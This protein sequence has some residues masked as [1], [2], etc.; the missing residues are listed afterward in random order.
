VRDKIANDAGD[1]LEKLFALSHVSTAPP[2][3]NTGDV[4]M[5]TMCV[6]EELAK[7]EARR[8]V[9]KE[10][11]EAME[12]IGGMADESLTWRLSQAAAARHSAERSRLND[13]TDLGEDRAA[14]SQQ[15]QRLI[16][17]EVWIKKKG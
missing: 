14:L 10:I 1:A 15:L 17:G 13:A 7:L 8:G 16:D 12:D 11:S 9:R 6:A 3:R 4:E 2:V 5:A